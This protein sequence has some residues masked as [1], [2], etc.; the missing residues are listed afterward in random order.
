MIIERRVLVKF[1]VAIVGLWSIIEDVTVLSL[2]YNIILNCVK[3]LCTI[4]Y[5]IIK[6]RLVPL[7]Y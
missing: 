4:V 1:P 6:M 7:P 2:Q 5:R 3:L